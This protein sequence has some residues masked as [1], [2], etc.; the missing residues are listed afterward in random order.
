MTP[1]Y[2]IIT[3]IADSN[4]PVLQV[5][6]K[7]SALHQIPL[8]VIGDLKSP[9]SFDLPHCDF[10]SIERQRTLSLSI[11][12]LLPHNHYARKNMTQIN[13]DNFCHR[14]QD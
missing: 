12:K 8:I 5:Y 4:N 9:A 1:K 13:S 3:S 10:Y 6:A 2:L 11:A 7:E 14:R